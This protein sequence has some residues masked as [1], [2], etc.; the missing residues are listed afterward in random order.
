MAEFEEQSFIQKLMQARK[1]SRP[2]GRPNVPQGEF[3]MPDVSAASLGENVAGD[4]VKM[5]PLGW[6]EMTV[7]QV[8][9]DVT[10]HTSKSKRFGGE[11]EILSQNWQIL[12]QTGLATTLGYTQAQFENEYKA[13]AKDRGGVGK[14]SIS[15]KPSDWILHPLKTATTSLKTLA[16][17]YAWDKFEA[18]VGQNTQSKMSV[19]N[20]YQSANQLSMFVAN[21]LSN[22]AQAKAANQAIRGAL[23]NFVTTSGLYKALRFAWGPSS[24]DTHAFGGSINGRLGHITN[25]IQHPMKYV[26]TN[27]IWGGKGKGFGLGEKFWKAPVIK[28]F[29]TGLLRG[30]FNLAGKASKV[31]FNLGLG[32]AS[33]LLNV[34]SNLIG[35]VAKFAFKFPVLTLLGAIAGALGLPLLIL[36]LLIVVLIP[37]AALGGQAAASS[38]GDILLTAT[39]NKTQ[40]VSA[41]ESINVSLNISA[42]SDGVGPINLSAELDSNFSFSSNLGGGSVEGKTIKWTAFDL[43]KGQTR[44]ISFTVVAGSSMDANTAAIIKA[45][46]ASSKYSSAA[47]VYFNRKGNNLGADGLHAFPILRGNNY[48]WFNCHWHANFNA[49]DIRTDALGGTPVVAV[50]SGTIISPSRSVGPAV[51]LV[52]DDG[53]TYYYGHLR[54]QN[55]AS[56]GKRVTTG[57]I[58]G[59]IAGANEFYAKNRGVA[60]VHFSIDTV[61]DHENPDTAAGDFLNRVDGTNLSKDSAG[62]RS[63]YPERYQ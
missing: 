57:E 15:T 12:Q 39:A 51:V 4:L 11:A 33:G 5:S 34:A 21:K 22:P 36:S 1:A 14:Y 8:Q 49:V 44:L 38:S 17:D 54:I 7:D 6:L 62:C 23:S 13:W 2:L 27:Y 32:A 42:Y 29:K 60:H 45:S 26:F 28:L 43:S 53:F 18:W 3:P 47:S 10:K 55:L 50:I 35:G 41:N 56:P 61:G 16:R 46:A 48:T 25:F 59:E 52:G 9:A 30:S 20:V 58:I 63:L 40:G 37:F 19:S 24:S 31:G